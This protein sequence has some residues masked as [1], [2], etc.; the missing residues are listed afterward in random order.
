MK[1]KI[2]FLL[3]MLTLF[4]LLPSTGFAQTTEILSQQEIDNL[5]TSNS[6]I[7]PTSRVTT[8]DEMNV[9]EDY[10]NENTNAME[11]NIEE[12]LEK[13]NLEH[14][15]IIPVEEMSELSDIGEIQSRNALPFR[16]CSFS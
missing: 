1:N 10:Y 8:L 13:L 12:I 5:L 3:V 15:E 6:V 4:T 2:S 11:E 9:I 14:V 7:S 16:Q